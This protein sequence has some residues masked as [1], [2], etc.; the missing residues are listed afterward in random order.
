MLAWLPPPKNDSAKQ[1]LGFLSSNYG[2]KAKDCASDLVCPPEKRDMATFVGIDNQGAT[3][4][5]SCVVQ[6]CYM[7]PEF[8][9]AILS[10]PLCV[11]EY[12]YLQRRVD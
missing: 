9:N 5:L 1:N 8:R 7:L 2:A 11:K 6:M 4:Y 10:L 12:F 3:D